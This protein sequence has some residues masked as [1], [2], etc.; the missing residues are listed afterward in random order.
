[1]NNTTKRKLTLSVSDNI[2]KTLKVKAIQYDV[3]VSELVEILGVVAERDKK[4]FNEI[5][6]KYKQDKLDK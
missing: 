5:V 1:M 6:N 2:V 4:L 3:T